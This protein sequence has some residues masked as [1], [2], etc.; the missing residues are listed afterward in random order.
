MRAA[1]AGETICDPA[2]GT[3]G[4]LLAA[5][6]FIS[7]NNRT[8]DKKQKTHLKLEALRGIELVDSVARLCAM[9]LL[10][11]GVGP[12][13]DE[14]DPPIAV[15]DSLRADP[16]D[17]FNVVLT[18]PPF[19]KKSS[20]RVVNE[21]GEEERRIF[22]R[23]W[24]SS[25]LCKP[26]CVEQKSECTAE[27]QRGRG[28]TRDPSIAWAEPRST[29][30][31]YHLNT[32]GIHAESTPGCGWG[33]NSHGLAPRTVSACRVYRFRHTHTV[34]RHAGAPATPTRLNNMRCRWRSKGSTGLFNLLGR[35]TAFRCE[36]VQHPTQEA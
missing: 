28:Q 21:E 7:A 8:L 14:A 15:D 12:E 29:L 36:I 11:H 33:D 25:R 13:G 3:G 26:G 34:I 31:P 9:N 10:L 18:N 17:R 35:T 6:D 5:H 2:C 22:G 19:G 23:R 32:L 4:F 16:G 20:V 27:T 1:A 24:R 30:T